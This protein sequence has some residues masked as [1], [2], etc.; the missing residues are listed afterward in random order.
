[1]IHPRS[2]KPASFMIYTLTH[3]SSPCSECAYKWLFQSTQ[4]IRVLNKVLSLG[5]WIHSSTTISHSNIHVLFSYNFH[6]REKYL[7][8]HKILRQVVELHSL[9][10]GDC[11][12]FAWNTAFMH[13]TLG[14]AL[15]LTGDYVDNV[16]VYKASK[17]NSK[18]DSLNEWMNEWPLFSHN[19]L[20]WKE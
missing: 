19:L 1:M 9:L 10:M 20:T 12:D 8:R 15:W 16:L 6:V 14:Q 11:W 5:K 13:L 3:I 7:R 4:K 17:G 18:D 2:S